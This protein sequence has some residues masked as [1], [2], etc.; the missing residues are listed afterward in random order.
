[1]LG[2]RDLPTFTGKITTASYGSGIRRMEGAKEE[3]ACPSTALRRSTAT[4]LHECLPW[5]TFLKTNSSPFRTPLTPGR[6]RR[7]I[8]V[9]SSLSHAEGNVAPGWDRPRGGFMV[10]S[11][12]LA[13]PLPA[14][15]KVARLAC[16]AD[17]RRVQITPPPSGRAADSN[18]ISARAWPSGTVGS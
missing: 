9:A 11:A 15:E 1:M 6:H 17:R 18:R 8:P 14:K 5:V 12:W 4:L 7:M 10:R 16:G 13:T 3:A 2:H